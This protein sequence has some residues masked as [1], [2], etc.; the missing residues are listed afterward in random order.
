LIVFLWVFNFAISWMNAWGVGKSWYETKHMGGGAHFMSWM[1]AIMAASGFTWCYLLIGGWLGATIPLEQD[2][3]SMATLLTP[4]DLQAFFDL[5][6]LVIIFPI[7]GSGLAITAHSWRYFWQ[8]RTFGGG[9]TA[10]YNTFAQIH[11]MYNAVQYVP[12][13][14]DNVGKLFG[15]GG[16]SKDGKATLIIILVAVCVLGGVLTTYAIIMSTMRS[17]A[18]SRR[19][20]YEM[21]MD[22][23]K[24]A[25][26]V[27]GA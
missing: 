7:L 10:G 26:A 11:N 13:A 24:A 6:Y 5:G 22:D 19:W 20:K 12:K 25:E 14:W 16:D 8:R 23:A 4:D 1:G 15:G 21:K 17:T 9:A 2:D 18:R 3:G 27:Q